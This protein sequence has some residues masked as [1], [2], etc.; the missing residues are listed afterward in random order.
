MGEYGTIFHLHLQPMLLYSHTGLH[1]DQYSSVSAH[2]PQDACCLPQE[3]KP[4]CHLVKLGTM[5]EYGTPNIDIE[6]GFLTV[7][8][9]GRTDTLPYPKQVLAALRMPVH[10]G[11]GPSAVQ[12]LQSVQHCRAQCGPKQ[13]H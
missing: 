2:E 7:T 1:L 6:E 5:G 12:R 9:N 4:D 11:W 13:L 10:C 3:H 8:H